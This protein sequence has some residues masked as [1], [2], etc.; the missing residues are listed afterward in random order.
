MEAL[1]LLIGEDAQVLLLCLRE[2]QTL[3]RIVLEEL[4]HREPM[5]ERL[6]LAAVGLDG[7]GT[8]WSIVWSWRIAQPDQPGA[9]VLE[10][11][12]T[13]CFDLLLV[14]EI[15][16]E[17]AQGFVVDQL[18]LARVA[19]GLVPDQVVLQRALWIAQAL[20]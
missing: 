5:Q 15:G 8:A 3:G 6:Y 2:L 10:G 20:C 14:F 18:G 19:F 1:D 7:L 16:E 17:R 12:G 13:Q 11:E 4:V 9:Q